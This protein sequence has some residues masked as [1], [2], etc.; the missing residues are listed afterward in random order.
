M[1][2]KEEYVGAD[3]MAAVALVEPPSGAGFT[4]EQVQK[5]LKLQV[6]CTRFE[7]P[8]EYTEFRLIGPDGDVSAMR[9]VDGY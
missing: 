4:P 1:F 7:N 2:L 8:E 6:W 3:A 5:A 9:R